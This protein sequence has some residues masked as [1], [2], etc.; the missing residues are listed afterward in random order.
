MSVHVPTIDEE[1]EEWQ[2]R[3]MDAKS[4][5]HLAQETYDVDGIVAARLEIGMCSQ[6]IRK[7][8]RLRDSVH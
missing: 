8:Q 3:Y 5:L 2:C 7:L 4:R 6:K 1:I